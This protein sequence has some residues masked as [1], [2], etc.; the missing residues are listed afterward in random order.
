VNSDS[1]RA[2]IV[3]DDEIS[4]DVLK[5]LLEQ[6]GIETLIITDTHNITENLVQARS[7]DV[8]F[9]DLEMPGENGYDV[10]DRLK[11][12]ARFSN[13]PVVAYTTHVS[14]MNQARDAGFHS[15]LGKPLND[16]LF[17]EQ[18]N[19]ILQGESVWEV[20]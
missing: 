5:Q 13:I 8:I 15:F 4:A 20:S 12:D 9:L 10:L 2:M 7:F 16:Y 3:E 11:N 14:H 19:R 17:P 6:V 18:L 1:I